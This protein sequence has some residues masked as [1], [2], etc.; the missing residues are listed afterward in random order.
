[1][2]RDSSWPII[3]LA[4]ERESML[5]RSLQFPSCMEHSQ[6]VRFSLALSRVLGHELYDWMWEMA[7]RA[8][9]RT[10]RVIKGY[11]SHII[12]FIKK[13]EGELQGK[14]CLQYVWTGLWATSVPYKP[15]LQMF[16]PVAC[17]LCMLLIVTRVNFSRWLMSTC[18]KIAQIFRTRQDHKF[19]L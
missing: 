10:Q 11:R 7:G 16:N 1:M 2:P 4:G 17:S 3:S 8:A 14:C 6:K 5:S 15:Y 12:D 9:G 13:L 18:K 19:E